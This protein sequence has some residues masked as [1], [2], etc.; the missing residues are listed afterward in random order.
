M[1]VKPEDRKMVAGTAPV[2]TTRQERL[3]V[4][5]FGHA[6]VRERH[7][8]PRLLVLAVLEERIEMHAA[9]AELLHVLDGALARAAV[10]LRLG[11]V[12]YGPR[13][14]GAA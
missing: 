6:I 9:P 10:R 12:H 14:D 4:L 3:T 7:R 8:A 1:M 2:S 5:C 13:R 11:C